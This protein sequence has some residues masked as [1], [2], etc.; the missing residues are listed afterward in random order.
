[1]GK[2]PREIAAFIERASYLGLQD[3]FDD[4]TGR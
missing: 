2:K 1:M 3:F 4:K